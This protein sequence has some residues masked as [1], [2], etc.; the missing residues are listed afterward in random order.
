MVNLTI[1]FGDC[2]S[3]VANQAQAFNTEAYLV[4]YSNLEDF[5]A[6]T[7]PPGTVIYTSLA[8]LPDDLE[9]AYQLL[10]R[11]DVVVYSPP[12][13]W[14][15][16]KQLNLANPRDSI[17]GTTLLVLTNI[18]KIKNNVLNFESPTIDN[19]FFLKLQDHRR[20]SQPQL[21]ISGCSN[22]H[23]MG[24]EN[25]QRYGSLLADRLN[26]P[27]SF[28]TAPGSSLQWQADQILRSDIRKNDIVVW[29]MTSEARFPW[30]SNQNCVKHVNPKTELSTVNLSKKIVNRLLVEE[31]FNYLA[32]VSANQVL[33]YC[34]K[35]GAKLLLAGLLSSD[36][37][38]L[39]LRLLNE[40]AQYFNLKHRHR[41]ID[42]GSDGI[43][44]GPEQHVLYADFCYNQLERLKYI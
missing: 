26:L 18:S 40:F 19:T 10:H 42:F 12:V 32:V 22:S 16:G 4:D 8:D 5:L 33:N 41:M 30:W 21:W 13:C 7:Q 25:N 35:V 38:S 3:S 2:D 11:A 37:L 9:L 23:A 28:L 17:E 36:T 34:N 6:E 24:V 29:G 20:G 43:H 39:R 31:H 1:F 44:P 15:D 27:V 14:S